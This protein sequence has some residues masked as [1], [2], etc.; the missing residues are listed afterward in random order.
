[1]HLPG[2]TLIEL[3]RRRATER[4]EQLVYSFFADGDGHQRQ[5]SYS[6]LDRQARAIGA[7]LQAQGAAGQ[8]ALLLYPPGLDFIA[9]FFGCLYAGVI[10]VPVYP[11]RPHRP[12]DTLQ[13][14]AADSGARFALTTSAQLCSLEQRDSFKPG[15]G[16]LC[17]LATDIP[18]H[19]REQEW[20]PPDIDAHSLAFLQYTSGS[21]AAPKGVMVS[22]ANLLHNLA[23][24]QQRTEQ[25]P[26]SHGVIWLPPYHDLGLIGGL[27]LPLYAGCSVS[28]MAPSSFVRS[29]LRWLQLISQTRA[30][31]SG[32]PNFA[33]DLCARTIADEH[34][35]ALDLS[36]WRVAFNGAEPI[37]AE[38]LRQFA[39]AFARCGFR[40]EAFFPCY[41]L[42]EATLFVSGGAV[43]T[44]PRV[45]TFEGT[46][47]EQRRVAA[48]DADRPGARSL[49]SSGEP[50]PD[51]RIAIVD[52]ASLRRCPSGQVGE[53]W[54]AGPSVAQG[55]W[56]QPALSAATFRAHT[57]DT[58]EGPFLR[59]GDLGFLYDG[60]LFV[61]GRIKDLIV[62][63]GR[64]YYP[65]DIELT[66]ERSHTAL[67]QGCC[68]AFSVEIA[69]EEQ[70]VVAQE[71]ERRH[72]RDDPAPIVSAVR[73]Q[74][75]RVHALQVYAVALVR[76]GRLPKTSSG[77]IQRQAC[78]AAFL[79]GRL[80]ILSQATL[81]RSAQKQGQIG[82]EPPPSRPTLLAFAPA[83]RQRTLERYTLAVIAQQ[84]GAAAEL[85]DLQRPLVELGLDSL[86]AVA[87]QHRLE[88]ALGVMLP[89]A[90]LLECAG[91]AEAARLLSERLQAPVDESLSEK[92]PLRH[93]DSKNQSYDGV[94]DTPVTFVSS[95][96]GGF[97]TASETSRA[98]W[99][100][101]PPERPLSAG[102]RA[103]WFLSRLAPRS[104]AYTI[105]SAVR[106]I[107]ALDRAAV[108]AALAALMER[109]A[110]LRTVFL[111]EEGMLVQRVRAAIELPLSER[112]ASGWSEE[113]I[114]AFLAEAAAQPFDLERGPLIRLHLL[115]HSAEE[116][117]LLVALHHLVSDLWSMGVLLHEFA[118]LY[119]ALSS[120]RPDPLPPL[121]ATYADYVSWQRNL[122]QSE[123][124]EQL[125]SYWRRR[126][127]GPLPVLDLPTD[128]RRP[129]A[130]SY[131]G[132]AHTFRIGADLA[133]RLR[134]LADAEGVTLYTLLLAAF[135]VL[136]ARYSGQDDILIG[137]PTAGRSQA[138]FGGQIGY[139]VNVVALRADCDQRQPFQT[140]LQQA[141]RTVL[142]A[143]ANQDYPLPMLVERLQ[144]SR[145]PSRP[146]LVQVLFTFQQAHL[147]PALTAFALG[148]PGARLDLGDLALETVAVEQRTAQFDITLVLGETGSAL[149]GMI[150]YNTDLF[151]Q[152][153]IVRMADHLEVL[154]GGIAAAPQT[155]IG[156]LPLLL[157]SAHEELR[158]GWSGDRQSDPPLHPVHQLFEAQAKRRPDA[159]AVRIDGREMSYAE[160]NRR[161]NQLARY[162]RRSGVGPGVAVGICLE[163]SAALVVSLLAVL[164]AGGVF[165]PLDPAHPAGRLAFMLEDSQAR[166]LIATNDQRPTTNDD[167]Q[168]T[169]DQRPTTNDQRPTANDE[170]PTTND[171]PFTLSSCHLVI[172]S[173]AHPLTR[174]P[175]HPTPA[176]EQESADD[177]GLRI[178]LAD[179]AY[180]VYTSGSTGAPK[181]V[182]VSGRS[183][184]N[185]CRWYRH[186]C[187]VTERSRVLLG[188]SFCFDAS[189][190]NI[191]TPLLVGGTLVL[192]D[193][194]PYDPSGLLR[195]I[196]EEQIT[197]VNATPSMIEPV[198]ERAAADEYHAL[199]SLEYLGLGGETLSLAPLRPWLTSA[200]S[201]CELFN[202]YGPTE[203]ADIS[204]AYHL[205]RADYDSLD[206]VPI[207]RPIDNMQAYILDTRSNL[208]PPGVV[209]ELYI[210]GV[211][212]AEGYLNRPDMT[213]ERF[214]PNPFADQRPT[215]ND[216]RP[217]TGTDD[218][219]SSF[220]VRR[221]S[222][223]YRTGDLA[224]YRADGTIEFLGRGDRQV[225]I[226]GV[227]IEPAEIEAAL[228][229]HPSVHECV[230]VARRD[231][232]GEQRLVAYVVPTT[233]QRPPTNDHRPEDQE[234]RRQGDKET[235]RQG[236]SEGETQ[237][238]TLNTQNFSSILHPPSSILGE[239]RAFLGQR[240]PQHMVPVAFMFLQR[241]PLTPN[242]KVDY[243]ALPAPEGLS[244]GA[245][246]AAAAP[247][248]DIEW[249]LLAIWQAVL[250]NRQV[251]IDDNFFDL[252]GHS[253]LLAQVQSKLHERGRDQVEMLDLLTY[254]TIRELAAYLARRAGAIR[255]IEGYNLG[256][257]MQ[258]GR[259]RLKQQLQ[260]RR[261]ATIGGD[262]DH[263]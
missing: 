253:L 93:K 76:T 230:V 62:I 54:L 203:C 153:T 57:A 99:Q 248:N 60:M 80:D 104:T 50:A 135:Q 172:L 49:V 1:M 167:W 134:A 71:L 27:L 181:G 228:Y 107:G 164:K 24:I 117:I 159:P 146:P 94:S 197:I 195:T 225:K 150:Q 196:A 145:D 101:A 144:P 83:E 123:R 5:Y 171:D 232:A 213:A 127:D 31:T 22:H 59:T 87:V 229:R 113:Q 100:E 91:I 21:T 245:R 89:M 136:L 208:Q 209:G 189:L 114:S 42:A 238:S 124:G 205:R 237:H 246:A 220:V 29:P 219:R 149:S 244:I 79:S 182:V 105:A 77:K 23:F 84:L 81:D 4:P 158:A 118:Q 53:I 35:A 157:A 231:A 170:R 112:D 166:V 6:E 19:S 215:T 25:T 51:Q 102:Q 2:Q 18:A 125:W 256:E 155:E 252:G 139:F 147:D 175:A 20:H 160:L 11:P 109:H 63:R 218:L 106:L 251:G 69:G 44:P 141:R 178:S 58:A 194:G 126:L 162:L 98:G 70:L 254:P 90:E 186:H 216:Q 187:P 14:I 173:P 121:T 192:A 132:A 12:L 13:H 188:L 37:R 263:G 130:Q 82:F 86:A 142:D 68:A 207:G 30:T 154:L 198:V 224:R 233:D 103:L 120:G 234:T 133:G 165:V 206:R 138:A 72:W 95:R 240:L 214:V 199:R 177:L 26:E 140:F 131:H 180:I 255:P 250:D 36:S 110:A 227:R 92:S 184:A 226:R 143:L 52:P 261:S 169:N 259:D 249:E 241:L 156:A 47:L 78:K 247:Q 73:Q 201:R 148:A 116:H 193:P 55:Y 122:L 108:R 236:E 262:S 191:L 242:G 88:T 34:K 183:L 185:L 163:R 168:P 176:I 190:K 97:Q 40:P 223:L 258:A 212:L 161:A 67:R 115:Q 128:R 33:Y 239:L 7:A 61:A 137:S 65:Q 221:S 16:S 32:A 257:K 9:A 202:V 48:A 111:L 260:R 74:V 119:S 235:R 243:Q 8:R 211:G 15:L 204:T 39:G 179:P 210:G 46:A 3:L 56:N 96:L 10:A 174:S 85:L 222:R 217:T 66:V 64:N 152:A 200:Q 41:G 43:A 38:T 129:S 75:A 28:L 17:W 151:D 45:A